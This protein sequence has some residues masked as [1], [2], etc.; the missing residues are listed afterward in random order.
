MTL[1]LLSNTL[2]FT[3]P[4]GL[5]FNRGKLAVIIMSC[6]LLVLEHLSTPHSVISAFE[7]HLLKFLFDVFFDTQE[8]WLDALHR[9]HACF[10]VKFLKALVMEPV[11][12][13]LALN[14]VNKDRLAKCAEEFRLQLILC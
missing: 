4:I 13:R 11:F 7:L 9:A 5:T 12:A 14:R 3:M 2:S 1:N 6:Y 8:L 10:V